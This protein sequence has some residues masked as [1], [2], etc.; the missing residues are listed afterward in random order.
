MAN[1]FAR[2]G[3]EA[4]SHTAGHTAAAAASSTTAMAGMLGSSGMSGMMMAFNDENFATTLFSSAWT[5][6]TPAAYAGTWLFLFFLAVIWRG[7]VLG[8]SRFDR[9]QLRKHEAHVILINGGKDQ[10]SRAS[11][12][13]A[14]RWSV[15]LPRAALATVNQGIAYLLYGIP[16]LGI[17]RSV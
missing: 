8:L 16:F 10:A 14:W 5:A 3:A 9:Y 12:V 1:V 13:A 2:H 4:S 17:E 6:T 7:L 11:T 15:N